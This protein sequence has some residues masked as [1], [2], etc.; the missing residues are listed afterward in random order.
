M[1]QHRVD[2]ATGI[3]LA[4]GLPLLLVALGRLVF[5]QTGDGGA[6]FGLVLAYGLGAGLVAGVY[7]LPGIVATWR[8]HHRAGTIWLLTLVC[9]CSGIG[10]LALL[11]WAALSPAAPP[12]P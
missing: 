2:V 11:C 5:P 7:G 6:A 4:L 12:A 9:G 3:G 1:Q 8:H 10:W